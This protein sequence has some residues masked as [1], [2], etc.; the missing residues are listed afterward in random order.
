MYASLERAS[1][2]RAQQLRDRFVVA[3]HGPPRLFVAGARV[4]T[5][6]QKESHRALSAHSGS[7]SN[8]LILERVDIRAVCEEVRDDAVLP[9]SARSAKRLVVARVNVCPGG[10][11]EVHD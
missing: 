1:G 10:E 8:R 11:Q 6:L 7:D 3:L 9:K 4:S 2:V 5:R